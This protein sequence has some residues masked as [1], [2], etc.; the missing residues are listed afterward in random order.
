MFTEKGDVTFNSAASPTHIEFQGSCAVTNHLGITV[1][2]FYGGSPRKS[3]EIGINAYTK[4]YKSLYF[5][6]TFG[7]GKTAI[8]NLHNSD[9]LNSTNYDVRVNY[10]TLFV[11]PSFYLVL[12]DDDDDITTRIGISFKYGINSLSNYYYYTYENEWHSSRLQEETIITANKEKFFSAS[13]LLSVERSMS[14]FTFGIHTGLA[15]TSGFKARYQY[16]TPNSSWN[17]RD[18][19]MQENLYYLPFVLSGYIGI[20]L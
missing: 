14:N 13:P 10:N 20:R 9:F 5:S 19:F 8:N 12:P 15:L 16:H 7:W 11:Q 4:V 2:R 1:G 17:N 18:Y 6:T 3:D